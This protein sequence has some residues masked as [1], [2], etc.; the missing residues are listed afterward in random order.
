ML[1][2]DLFRLCLMRVDIFAYYELV[3]AYLRYDIALTSLTLALF[4]SPFCKNAWLELHEF[5][6]ETI[7]LYRLIIMLY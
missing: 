1:D 6:S 7:F 2:F 4:P 3:F 5:I